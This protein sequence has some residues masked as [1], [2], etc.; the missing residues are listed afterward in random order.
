M[1]NVSVINIIII[2]IIINIM[3]LLFHYLIHSCQIFSQT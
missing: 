3:K 2:M 1:L